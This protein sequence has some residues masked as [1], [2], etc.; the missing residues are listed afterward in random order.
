MRG[1]NVWRPLNHIEKVRREFDRIFDEFFG[2]IDNVEEYILSPAV[3]VY[4]TDKDIVIKAEIPGA[5]KDEIEVTVKDNF[6]HIKAEK[7]EEKEEK[8]ENIHKIERFYGRVE[9][10][11]P[12]PV[13]VKS[14][15]AKAEYKDGVLEIRIPKEKTSKETKIKIS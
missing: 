4:E 10:T 2:R 13:D 6:V 8:K 15:E 11:I 12:L 7:K 3:D 14:E 5:K 1:L 9:R